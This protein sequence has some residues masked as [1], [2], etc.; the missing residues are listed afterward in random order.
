MN[1]WKY[2]L[3]EAHYIFYK[4]FVESNEVRV[5][6][7]RIINANKGLWA[8]KFIRVHKRLSNDTI[9]HRSIHGIET[10]K[11]IMHG[12]N[13]QHNFTIKQKKKYFFCLL[14]GVIT[15]ETKDFWMIDQQEWLLNKIQVKCIKYR[16]LMLLKFT[17]SSSDF[18]WSFKTIILVVILNWTDFNVC[19][20]QRL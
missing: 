16:F 7:N 6:W 15:R 17:I 13:Y 9:S 18:K 14:H 4:D 3:L 10:E 11:R 20:K 1:S 8:S 2:I 5:P 12:W 19:L